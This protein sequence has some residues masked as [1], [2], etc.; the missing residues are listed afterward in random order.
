MVEQGGQEEWE[1]SCYDGGREEA[2]AVVRYYC[3]GWAMFSVVNVQ[4]LLGSLIEYPGSDGSYRKCAHKFVPGIVAGC[5]GCCSGRVGDQHTCTP[6]HYPRH[7][8]SGALVRVA[9]AAVVL[10]GTG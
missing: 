8:V 3:Q 1:L 7:R 5:C 2:V 4:H 10:L 6:G 9:A